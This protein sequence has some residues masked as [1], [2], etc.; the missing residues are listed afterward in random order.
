[1]LEVFA[2]QLKAGRKDLAELI[3]VE[4]GK[5]LW[6]SDEEVAA[7]AGKVALSISAA[8]ERR[9]PTQLDLAG[10]TAAFRQGLL[11][12]PSSTG[13]RHALAG[14]LW[15]GGDATEAE[16]LLRAVL[17]D[18]ADN[19]AATFLLARILMAQG[20]ML[21][22]ETCVRALFARPRDTG[23]L[24]HAIELLDDCG[25][26]Q[27][28]SE[29]VEATIG[30]GSADPRLHAY[31]GML[32]MQLGEFERARARYRFA[33]EHDARA[34]EWQSAYG[35]AMCK[36]YATAD[37]P[38]FELLRGLLARE[39][40]GEPAR[41]SLLFA[42]GKACDDIG[43]PAQAASWLRE[44]NTLAAKNA[45]WSRKA[46]RRVVAARLDA[47]PIDGVQAA[48]PDFVPVFVVGLPRSGTTLV[49]ERLARRARACHRGELNW[50]AQLA[51]KLGQGGR[52][53]SGAYARAAATYAAQVRQDDTDARW[54]IDKQPLNFLHVDLILA[55]FP[56]ARIIHCRRNA[57]DTALSIWM[58]YF[59]GRELG[60]AY[61]FADIAAVAQGCERLMAAAGTRHRD[62][63][64][65]VRYEDL[66]R[67][68]DRLIGELAAWIG[69]DAQDAADAPARVVISTASAWQAR[70]PVH[71]R[72][73]G[74]W[75]VYAGYV[76]EL[77]G[78]PD[79]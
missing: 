49:A 15:Q 36:R 13:L 19:V 53:G 42:L 64:R 24:I 60:F 48:D 14:V 43:D 73:V 68:P 18:D 50:I 31:A 9:S 6:E 74:R 8:K 72:S 1:V 30:A 40:L 11:G 59:A 17:K 16:A 20:R 66:V 21:A 78:I 65:D 27:A 51:Q 5:P 12:D 76:P 28:A 57:R 67:E 61:D 46:W 2:E 35:H 44:A 10:A 55:L 58:Q 71:A 77:L 56:Q 79:A 25:R 39:D 34:V 47:A 41:A 37:D 33:L 75:R 70:Q 52:P 38:D 32:A 54:F 3:S 69:L 23:T 29:L 63:I 4:T 62:A 7:M 22:V 26:K 45:G